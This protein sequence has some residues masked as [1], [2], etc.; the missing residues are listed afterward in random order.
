MKPYSI[1]IALNDTS[2]GI[3]LPIKDSQL[4]LSDL[5][6]LV[7]KPTSFQWIYYKANYITNNVP[8]AKI[9][10]YDIYSPQTSLAYSEKPFFTSLPVQSLFVNIVSENLAL[11]AKYNNKL[12]GK[13]IIKV[14]S[15]VNTYNLQNSPKITL[16]LKPSFYELK[17]AYIPAEKERLVNEEYLSSLKLVRY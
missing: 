7:P 8:I 12:K 1:L 11:T 17:V 13:V 5:K 14:N 2:K 4:G 6:L 3:F 10:E 15:Q 9:L 16:K